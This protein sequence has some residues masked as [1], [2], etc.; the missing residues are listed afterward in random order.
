MLQIYTVQCKS[1]CLGTGR[2]G[3]AGIGNG[4]EQFIDFQNVGEYPQLHDGGRRGIMRFINVSFTHAH[5][6]RVRTQERNQSGRFEPESAT[7]TAWDYNN[8]A[9]APP[10]TG[11]FLH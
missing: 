1:A 5:D 8:F 4:N 10:P 9:G 2:D 7:A 3:W 6:F 11:I